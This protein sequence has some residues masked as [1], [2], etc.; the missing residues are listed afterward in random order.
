MTR[1][2]DKQVWHLRA[3]VVKDKPNAL[4]PWRW[5]VEDAWIPRMGYEL[6]KEGRAV[7]LGG[8]LRKATR[9]GISCGW[10]TERVELTFVEISPDPCAPKK[11]RPPSPLQPEFLERGDCPD[12]S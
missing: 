3:V 10:N 12:A 9:R 2:G 11:P 5:A 6:R 4:R 1:Q 8:A 7:T